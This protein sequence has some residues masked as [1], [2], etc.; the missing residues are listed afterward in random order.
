MCGSFFCRFEQNAAITCLTL[1]DILNGCY[2]MHCR[3]MHRKK[4][5]SALCRKTQVLESR[6]RTILSTS[7]FFWEPCLHSL[8]SHV[9]MKR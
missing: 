6:Q 2:C 3:Y 5:P 4:L 7:V 1:S 9:H 8:Q